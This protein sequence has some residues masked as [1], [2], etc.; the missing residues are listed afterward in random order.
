MS[1]SAIPEGYPR[2]SP[3]LIVDDPDATLTFVERVFDGLVVGRHTAPDGR[4]MHAEV[5]V[6]DS[7]VMLG[8]A[9]AQWRAVP[10]ALHIYVADADAAYRRALDAGARAVSEPTT[11][12][13]GDRSAYVTDA[14]GTMW[15]I[16][17]RVEDVP[18]DELA[19]R[20]MK[21]GGA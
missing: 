8:G 15:F 21:G 20:M 4:V 6:G 11:Q 13:Y 18:V 10:A 12:P 9:N 14:C 3:Y 1:V 7:L 19:Q 2:I 17:S 16:S 5:R